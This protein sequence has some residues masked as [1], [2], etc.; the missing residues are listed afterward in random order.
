MQQEKKDSTSVWF[1][2]TFVSKSTLANAV[3]L[4]PSDDDWNDFALRT[5]F[6]AI[7]IVDGQIMDKEVILLGFLE[8]N[9][10]PLSV[11]A[12]ILLEQNGLVS[13]DKFPAYFTMR[14][15]MKAYRGL[16]IKHGPE[17]AQ[18]YLLATNDLVVAQIQ[19][20]KPK[21]LKVA[22]NTLAFT[23]SFMREG[24]S[25]FVFHNAK[26]ILKGL[27]HERFEGISTEFTLKFKLPTFENRHELRFEYAAKD[28]ILPSRIAVIIGENGTGKSQAL[29]TLVRSV[30]ADDK[31]FRTEG[32]ERPRINRLLAV[33]SPGE[34]SSTF[35]PENSKKAKTRY[36]RLSIS[37]AKA[38]STASGLINLF[39]QLAR[40]DEQLGDRNRWRLFIET[41][42]VLI[43]PDEI[44]LRFTK[45]SQDS[46]TKTYDG[47]YGV[48]LTKLAQG[49][50]RDAL[51]M[52][53]RIDV[54][55]DPKRKAGRSYVPLS[56]GQI[57]FLRF[58]A[59]LCLH[60]ENG[61][62]VLL[63]EPE[64]HLHPRL[65]SEFV[66][67]L[68]KILEETGSLALIA[69]HSAYFVRETRASQVVVLRQSQRG[70][71]EVTQPR[72]K[73]LGADVG[74]ISRF[75]FGSTV[76]S[77]LLSQLKASMT[78][79]PAQR[80]AMIKKLAE[81]LPVEAQMFLERDL[82]GSS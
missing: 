74:A 82:E 61:T 30:L 67:L 7:H 70:L 14:P 33:E 41:I 63:D 18:S 12:S 45:P 1:S 5:R 6:T 68:S 8:T 24:E 13:S 25:F 53:S 16:V 76:P 48:P 69:T 3:I 46:E 54:N 43:P 81:H 2:K 10:S 51:D 75:V 9:E 34:A 42:G 79:P 47:R 62:L 49:A 44:F 73:T 19:P 80:A 26:H 21:W 29:R 57:T 58:A 23:R 65:I 60:V 35:P 27:Q 56:S 38:G 64:T 22:Q 71:I 52:W 59:Q 37:R 36:H 17:E 28:K 72:L 15:T 55:H 50:F 77:L 78:E 66:S 4:V 31:K 11:A 20:R 32:N 40:S 39:V